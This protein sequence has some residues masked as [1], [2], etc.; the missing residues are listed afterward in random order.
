MLCTKAIKPTKTCTWTCT[1]ST[2][3]TNPYDTKTIAVGQSGQKCLNLA[4]KLTKCEWTFSLGD[5]CVYWSLTHTTFILKLN[6]A[7]WKKNSAHFTFTC[8][9]TPTKGGHQ[10]TAWCAMQQSRME[11]LAIWRWRN[12]FS[13]AAFH[14]KVLLCTSKSPYGAH[15]F[16]LRNRPIV[17]DS[18]HYSKMIAVLWNVHRHTALWESRLHGEIARKSF[19]FRSHS[20]SIM[21]ILFSIL[22]R[23]HRKTRCIKTEPLFSSSSPRAPFFL[24]LFRKEVALGIPVIQMI[25]PRG[26]F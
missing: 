24:V 13:K 25:Y 7:K 14:R 20:T 6:G 9:H 10:V 23:W 5:S 15:L 18:Y 21:I 22:F 26:S 17:D 16:V 4:H 8:S 19:R 1:T 11:L 3:S 2:S 12:D